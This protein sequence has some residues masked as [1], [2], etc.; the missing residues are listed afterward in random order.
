MALNWPEIY[1]ITKE[2]KKMIE[3]RN[4]YIKDIP[5]FG[6]NMPF[7]SSSEAKNAYS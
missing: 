7:V 5:I 2:A 6:M 1:Q 3:T 4:R